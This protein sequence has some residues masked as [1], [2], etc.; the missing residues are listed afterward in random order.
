MLLICGVVIGAAGLY[1]WRALFGGRSTVWVENAL[2]ESVEIV[3]NGVPSDTIAPGKTLRV[4]I[5]RRA[6]TPISWQV[7]R[8]GNPPLGEPM[9]GPLPEADNKLG[10]RVSQVTALVEGQR[11]FAPLVTNTTASDITLEVNP[12]TAVAARCGCLVPRG[13]ARAHVGYYRLYANSTVA[14]YNVAHPYTGPH[15]DRADFAGAVPST[16]GVIELT[17]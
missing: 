4:W 1:A 12:G 15:S 10:R 2:V 9:G 5:P 6:G 17:Y 3:R 8:P 7:L 13:A 14:A 16:S 11:Y